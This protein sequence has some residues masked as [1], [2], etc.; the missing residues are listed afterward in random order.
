MTPSLLNFARV[1]KAVLDVTPGPMWAI[2]FV[3]LR[4]A[5]SRL[6]LHGMLSTSHGADFFDNVLAGPDAWDEKGEYG[7]NFRELLRR[8]HA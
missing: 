4:M 8:N 6:Y 2:M 7:N 3:E 1:A 5:F